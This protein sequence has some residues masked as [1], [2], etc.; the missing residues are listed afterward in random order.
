MADV[1]KRLEETDEWGEA[2]KPRIIIRKRCKP[3]RH[4]YV[5]G[6]CIF[7]SLKEGFEDGL[8]VTTELDEAMGNDGTK[9]REEGSNDS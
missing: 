4:I 8:E 2:C 7:C 1:G 9:K 3:G 6:E 5:K